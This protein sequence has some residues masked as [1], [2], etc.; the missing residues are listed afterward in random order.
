MTNTAS[1]VRV[2]GHSRVYYRFYYEQNK[3]IMLFL[4][5]VGVLLRAGI[6]PRHWN[7]NRTIIC[8]RNRH[9]NLL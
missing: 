4:L 9:A 1:S 5:R 8:R 7:N 3:K 6:Y 2:M